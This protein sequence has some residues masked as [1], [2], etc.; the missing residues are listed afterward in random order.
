MHSETLDIHEQAVKL[1]EDTA[2]DME[3]L[4]ARD[5]TSLDRDEKG[6]YDVLSSQKDA[7]QA[8]LVNG[9]DYE[10]RHKVIIERFGRYPHRN[11]AI[12]REST[13]E[14]IDYLEN[15]GETFG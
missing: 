12:G 8:Y 11:Q 10:K 13:K 7:L 9:L 3:D 2:R 5:A 6:C 14:E 1:H 15:G 4:L